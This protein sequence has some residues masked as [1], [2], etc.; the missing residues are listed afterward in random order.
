MCSLLRKAL[1]RLHREESGQSLIIMIS[2]MTV[3][4]AV[5]AY[6]I[7]AAS[8]MVR[9]HQAQVI[10]DSAAMAAA[11]CLAN[12]GQS[13]TININGT[14]TAVPACSSS[15]DTADAQTDA[16][17]Y[18]AANGL[19][20]T[21]SNVVIDT[22]KNTVNVTTPAHSSATFATMFGLG[23]TTQTAVAQA[24]WT[25]G[26]SD[27]CTA[28]T[29]DQCSAVYA[30][31]TACPSTNSPD[32]AQSPVSG[33]QDGNTGGGAT[34]TVNGVVHSEGGITVENS[35]PTFNGVPPLTVAGDCY[36]SGDMPDYGKATQVASQSW[37]INYAASPYFTA[38]TTNCTTVNGIS[39]VP[40]YCTQATTSST[41]YDFTNVNDNADLPVSG[42]VYCAIGTGTPSNPATWNGA[43]QIE[44]NYPSSGCGS[45]Y[46]QVTFI[47]GNISFITD[48]GGGTAICLS[49]D[50]DNCLMYS[51]GNINIYNGTFNWTGNIFDPSGTI[52]LGSQGAG[53]DNDTSTSGM[54]EGWNVY[55]IN[56]TLNLTGDGPA[57]GSTG[58]SSGGTDM[59]EQ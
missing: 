37:P 20:I 53:G 44:A 45:S 50:L 24:G 1:R 40:P 19:T 46:P 3:L 32:A 10:A 22:T 31:N 49:P 52:Q 11:H 7:D 35:G 47:G 15:S 42:N 26:S 34:P 58:G 48:N 27:E 25:A 29:T 6:G 43:I 13:G 56:A 2:S 5:A 30:G 14:S 18:A 36:T 8:W 16:V 59:L 51:T 9:H 17:A 57:P 21:A 28:A 38:C 12:P 55:M 4:L 41:G 23:S 54:L 39:G 33:F